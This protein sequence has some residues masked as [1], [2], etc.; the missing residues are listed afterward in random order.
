M[1]RQVADLDM[2]CAVPVQAKGQVEQLAVAVF[3]GLLHA[4][5]ASCRAWFGDVRDRRL[6]LAVEVCCRL[7]R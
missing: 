7:S 3:R 2:C 1:Y 6:A 5:P 4:L